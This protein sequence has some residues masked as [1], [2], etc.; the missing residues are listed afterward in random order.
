MYHNKMNVL[1]RVLNGGMSGGRARI[2]D[3]LVKEVDK[4]TDDACRLKRII[5]FVAGSATSGIRSKVFNAYRMTKFPNPKCKDVE[6]PEHLD[7]LL[8]LLSG[9]VLSG[10][11]AYE[12]CCL[13]YGSLPTPEHRKIFVSVLEKKLGD[14]RTSKR[15]LQKALGMQE[16][17]HPCSLGYLFADGQKQFDKSVD[18]GHAWFISR[19]YDG[20]RATFVD[21]HFYSRKGLIIK[22]LEDLAARMPEGR[23]YDGEVCV[24]MA[25]DVENFNTA[26]SILRRSETAGIKENVRFY[27]FDILT[28]DEFR[29]EGK[30]KSV[31]LSARLARHANLEF[32]AEVRLIEQVKYSEEALTHMEKRVADC[33]WEGLIVRKDA[34]YQGRR[35]KDVLKIKTFDDDEYVV[36]DVKFSDKLVGADTNAQRVPILA[37]FSIEHKGR[38]VWVGSGLDEVQRIYYHQHPE[39]LIGSVVTVQYFG[40]TPDGSLRHPS[41]KMVHGDK[42]E[43]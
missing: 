28:G 13:Y 32:P 17:R 8:D 12:A 3:E 18:A 7:D 43:L 21:G 1:F 41:L 34:P 2:V 9:R 33:G 26:V 15:T 29:G 31:T 39:E 10:H 4:G 24:M 36:N 22:S 37:A 35:T 14:N 27:L 6:C 23:V 19:K 42:R 38:E 30:K 20:M 5:R 40:E 11:A 25:N 16:L